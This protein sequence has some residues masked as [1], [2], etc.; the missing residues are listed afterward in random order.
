MTQID[1]SDPK[2][3]EWNVQKLQMNERQRDAL[4]LDNE[5]CIAFID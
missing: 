2:F 4:M 5:V 1:W 3:A